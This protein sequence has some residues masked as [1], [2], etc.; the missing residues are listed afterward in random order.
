MTSEYFKVTQNNKCATALSKKTETFDIVS[1]YSATDKMGNLKGI[2]IVSGDYTVCPIDKC[3]LL[4]AGTGGVYS[5]H[6]SVDSVAGGKWELNYKR[7]QLHG[8]EAKFILKC[9]TANNLQTI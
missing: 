1:A 5:G 9:S 8:Y 4:D 6:V 3:E 2:G 7:D